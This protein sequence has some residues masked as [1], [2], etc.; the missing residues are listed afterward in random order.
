MS[1]NNPD[2]NTG[3]KYCFF[4]TEVFSAKKLPNRHALDQTGFLIMVALMP[5][6]MMLFMLLAAVS[7]VLN[8][9]R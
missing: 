5:S 4:V 6:M 3:C 8:L 7:A 9:A 1:G 2:L